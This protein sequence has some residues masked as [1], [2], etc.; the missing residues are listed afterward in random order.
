MA[1]GAFRFND[2]KRFDCG[3]TKPPKRDVTIT[4]DSNEDLRLEDSRLLSQSPVKLNGRTVT[5]EYHNGINNLMKAIN[6][7][8]NG[9]IVFMH[10]HQ[11]VSIYVGGQRKYRYEH[12]GTMYMVF[13]IVYQHFGYAIV[14]GRGQTSGYNPRDI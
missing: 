8:T 9:R 5:C 2:R 11:G 13:D 7:L 6:K 4:V 1:H 3:L 10:E 12:I 14:S